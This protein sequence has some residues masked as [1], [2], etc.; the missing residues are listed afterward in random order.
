MADRKHSPDVLAELLGADLPPSS[1]P[2]LQPQVTPKR[3]ASTRPATPRSKP[4]PR[5]QP[6]PE[7]AVAAA[8]ALPVTDATPTWETEV[9]TFQQHRGWR[10]RYVNGIELKDW[11]SGPLIHEY[12]GG[13]GAEGWELA[14]TSAVDRFYGAADNL[15]LYF[16]RRR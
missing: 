1:G 5:S 15:Q 11:L 6:Q 14:G 13:R 7:I 8:Q 12:L 3:S 10:P 16:K 2:E 9:V 4:E